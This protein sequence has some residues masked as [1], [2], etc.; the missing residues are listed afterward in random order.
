M[1]LKHLNFHMQQHIKQI[2]KNYRIENKATTESLYLIDPYTS[3]FFTSE[4][5]RI[6]T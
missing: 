5:L 4:K 3:N 6:K 1:S 2:E